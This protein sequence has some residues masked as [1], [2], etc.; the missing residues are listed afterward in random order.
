MTAR[1]ALARQRS[2]GVPSQGKVSTGWPGMPKKV[3][4][5]FIFYILFCPLA[6]P[7]CRAGPAGNDR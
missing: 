5:F 3:F 7:A 4:N 6:G 1:A 2:A